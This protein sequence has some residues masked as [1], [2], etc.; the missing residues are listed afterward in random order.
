M[1][2]IYLKIENQQQKPKNIDK[3]RKKT[4]TNVSKRNLRKIA[5]VNM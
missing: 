2:K 5:K 4:L 3:S 1:F